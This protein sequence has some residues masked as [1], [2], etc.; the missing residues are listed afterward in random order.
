MGLWCP[1]AAA[2]ARARRALVQAQG[3]FQLRSLRRALLL[4]DRELRRRRRLREQRR[5]RQET[6]PRRLGRKRYEE[7]DPEVQLSEE[8]PESLRSL[9][10][11]GN[12]L[13]DRFKS[14]QRRNLIEPR[15]RAKFRRRYRVK[16]VEKRSFRAVTL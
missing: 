3:L 16:Y 13:R 14:L 11:E 6:A 8:L 12:V 5:E 1:Q 7:P 15:D 9:R 10:P 4:R 2:R